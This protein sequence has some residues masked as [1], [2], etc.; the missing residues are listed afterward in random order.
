MEEEKGTVGT[1]RRIPPGIAALAVI[2]LG[3]LAI[4]ACGDVDLSKKGG[5]PVADKADS[6]VVAGSACVSCHT[7]KEKLKM[8]T[9][10]IKAPPKSSLTSGKG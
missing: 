5:T 1:V 8:E 7:D 6:N 4:T 10:S 2:A 9:A 3:A